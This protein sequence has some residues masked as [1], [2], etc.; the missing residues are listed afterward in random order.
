MFD[1]ETRASRGNSNTSITGLVT[2]KKALLI[3]VIKFKFKSRTI[4]VIDNTKQITKFMVT[5]E[6]C[7]KS[8]GGVCDRDTA[9]IY[10][11]ASR[12]PNS[13]TYLS[14]PHNHEQHMLAGPQLGRRAVQS[15]PLGGLSRS[16]SKHHHRYNHPSLSYIGC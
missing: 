3:L 4:K 6:P 8:G 7:L 9:I 11:V 14:P 12:G 13:S 2:E 1:K 16:L 10:S 15:L 5:E